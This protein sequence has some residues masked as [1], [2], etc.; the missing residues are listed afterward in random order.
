MDDV[1]D[2]DFSYFEVEQKD[3]PDGS[4]RRVGRVNDNLGMQITGLSCNSTYWFRVVAYDV[5]GNRGTYSDEIEVTTTK[6]VY[7]P[8]ITHIGPAPGY[9]SERIRLQANATDNE[10]VKTYTFQITY[11]MKTWKEDAVLE[12]LGSP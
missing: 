8:V 1:E 10:G 12:Q 7:A 2:E 4:F 11:D 9:Y 6:D 5:L 3:S